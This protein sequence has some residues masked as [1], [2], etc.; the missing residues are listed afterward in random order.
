MTSTIATASNASR[1]KWGEC[2]AAVRLLYLKRKIRVWDGDEN[3]RMRTKRLGEEPSRFL[4]QQIIFPIYEDAREKTRQVQDK[5]YRGGWM[6]EEDWRR[7]E[8]LKSNE[9]RRS[10]DISR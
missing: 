6:R 3:K 7:V 2:P 1:Q 9:R 5:S 10:L 4:K 8:M